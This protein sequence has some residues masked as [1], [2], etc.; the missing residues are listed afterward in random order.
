LIKFDWRGTKQRFYT[1]LVAI[2]R[3]KSNIYY[4]E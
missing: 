3:P 1:S 2:L 4:T